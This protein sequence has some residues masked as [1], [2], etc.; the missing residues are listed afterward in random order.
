MSVSCVKLQLIAS[1]RVKGSLPSR[2]RAC[3]YNMLN[4]YRSN[5]LHAIIHSKSHHKHS[6]LLSCSDAWKGKCIDFNRDI[7][8]HKKLTVIKLLSR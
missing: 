5:R 6:N 7:S 4:L 1:Y 8:S 3:R 2:G